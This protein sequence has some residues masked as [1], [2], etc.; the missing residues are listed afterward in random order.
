MG[1]GQL[2]NSLAVKPRTVSTLS[3]HADDYDVFKSF[4]LIFSY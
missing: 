3:M 4:T 1:A 2:K